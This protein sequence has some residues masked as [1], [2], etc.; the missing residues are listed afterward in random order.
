MNTNTNFNQNCFNSNVCHISCS[1]CAKR[2]V[3]Q[4][5]NKF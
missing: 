3:G 2:Y 1:E 5:R 4:F